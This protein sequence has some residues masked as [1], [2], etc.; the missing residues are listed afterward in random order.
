M[1]IIQNRKCDA[2]KV[3]ESETQQ[4]FGG[5]H[6]TRCDPWILR[7]FNFISVCCKNQ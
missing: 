2:G 1:E 3:N 4:I 5:K 7:E 6:Q